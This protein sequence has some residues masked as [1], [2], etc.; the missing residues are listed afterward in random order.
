MRAI[1]GIL[2]WGFMWLEGLFDH[3]F[4][5][6]W[7]PMYYLGGLG[8]FYFWIVAVSGLYLYIFFDT[9]LTEAYA[10][11]EYMTHDQWYLAGVMRSLHRYASDA[12]VVMMVLHMTREFAFDHFRGPRFFSWIT[13]VPMTWLIVAAGVTGYWLVWD[14]LA[15]YVAITS[16]EWL[17]WLPIFGEPIARNFLTPSSLDDRFFTLLIFLHIAVPLILLLVM[18]I[19]LQRIAYAKWNPPHGLSVGTMA[20][21]VGLS[22]VAPAVSH[23]PADLA[24]VPDSL[25]LDWY[26]LFAYPAVEIVGAGPVWAFAFGATFLLMLLPWLPPRKAQ[27]AA[28]VDLPNCNGCTRCAEDCPFNAITMVPRRD[29]APYERQAEVSADLCVSCGICVGACP[30][31]MPFRRRSDLVPGIDLPHFTAADLRDAV[32]KATERLQGDNRVLVFG[33]KHGIHGRKLE[34]GGRVGIDL[35]CAA[36]VPPAFIDY[37]LS[38][39][40]ADGVAVV[41]CRDGECQYRLGPEWSEAR[42]ERRRDPHLRSRVPL[43][44]LCRIWA[45]PLAWRS[46]ERELDEFQA[47]LGIMPTSSTAQRIR[48]RAPAKAEN[49]K[50]GRDI[51]K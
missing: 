14:E 33:C 12:L 20:M 29:G 9:G 32:H 35:P 21:M 43:E 38:K 3:V 22:L 26:Y 44:R 19:H 13:G 5:P 18:W 41:G 50:S 51:G 45:T 4:T 39:G 40:M 11:V 15:Q 24:K 10:S 2:R 34:G 27:P 23:G 17:D 46:A 42:F 31:A 37:V 1:K 28:V 49:V 48:Q 16:S 8:F 36:M 6:K 7:N 25:N 47:A 30:T